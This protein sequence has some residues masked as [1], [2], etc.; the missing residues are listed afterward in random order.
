MGEMPRWL[1]EYKKRARVMDI[2]ALAFETDCDCEVC[3]ELRKWAME[4][5]EE[6]TPPVPTPAKPKT[7]KKRKR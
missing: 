4:L 5:D 1:V 7:K 2:L 6:I 3:K